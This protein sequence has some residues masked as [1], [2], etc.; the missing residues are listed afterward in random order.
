M[1]RPHHALAV[2]LLA[3]VLTVGAALVSRPEK[4]QASWGLGI[5]YHVE[6]AYCYRPDPMYLGYV[7]Y[8]QIVHNAWGV[9]ID[10]WYFQS[11]SRCDT[12]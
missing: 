9:T 1:T 6:Y 7:M 12:V 11:Q 4:A 10:W 5:H 8:K 3:A 2:V